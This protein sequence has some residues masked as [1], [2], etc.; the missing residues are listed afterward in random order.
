MVKSELG[1]ADPM[2]PSYWFLISVA[3][4][5]RRECKNAD[6]NLMVWT[7]NEPE[8]M[9]EVLGL[10]ASFHVCMNTDVVVRL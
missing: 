3:Y 2:F 10:K 1:C 8:Q 6:K 4:R 5:F 7:V 9:M